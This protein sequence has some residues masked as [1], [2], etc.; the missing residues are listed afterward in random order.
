MSTGGC[1]IG[2]DGEGMPKEFHL[3]LEKI[4]CLYTSVRASRVA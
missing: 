4:E 3:F 2:L 1:G